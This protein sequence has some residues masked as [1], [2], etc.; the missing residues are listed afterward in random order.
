MKVYTYSTARQRLSEVL[1]EASREGQVQI[2]LRM[3]VSMQCPPCQHRHNRP[4]QTSRDDPCAAS[5]PRNW[6]A[7][8]V[9][10]GG[11]GASGRFAVLVPV[12]WHARRGACADAMGEP[13]PMRD[14]TSPQS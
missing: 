7:L 6:C 13:S 5:L 9:R 3:V 10:K 11:H 2:R 14:D 12:L 8:S 1:E 4:L